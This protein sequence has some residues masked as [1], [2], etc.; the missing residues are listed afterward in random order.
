[1]PL[2][3]ALPNKGRLMEDSTHLLSRVGMNITRRDDRQLYFTVG[4]KY[5]VVSMRAQD[6]PAFVSRG[7]VDIGLTGLDIVLESGSDV[8][9]LLDLNFGRCRLV[10]AVPESS[11]V[12]SMDD[13]PAGWKVATAHPNLAS[14]FFAGI[15]RDVEILRVSGA[16]EIAPQMGIA[17]AVVDITETGATLKS[18]GLRVLHTIMRSSAVLIG[19][20]GS[21]SHPG[22]SEFVDAVRSVISAS[23]MRYLMAN[24]PESRLDEVRVLMPGVSAP[25]IVPL[26]GKKGVVAVHAVV[27]QEDVNG[28]IAMLRGMGA[29]GILVLR[30][31]R[32]VE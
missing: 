7:S 23:E 12:R 22:T 5:E 21:M 13:V 14:T 4:G 17:D 20:R 10:V 25:T 31:E 16:T 29:T 30:I 15:G 19:R 27:A 2:T 32:M 6:I 28:V 9:R 11:S 1:M 26:F 3:I 24:V 18:N 8:D